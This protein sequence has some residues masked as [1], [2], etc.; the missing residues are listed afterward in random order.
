MGK[1]ETRASKLGILAAQEVLQGD[2]YDDRP[3]SPRLLD[4][5][6][7]GVQA[8]DDLIDA[9]ARTYGWQVQLLCDGCRAVWETW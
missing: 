6:R 3:N 8:V 1:V 4:C 5:E 9:R 2:D 7:C